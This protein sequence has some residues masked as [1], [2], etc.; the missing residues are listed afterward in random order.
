MKTYTEYLT[1]QTEKASEI[2][3][4][5]DKVKA[6]LQKSEFREGLVLV[7]SLHAN[8]GVFVSIYEPLFLEDLEAWL[9]TLSPLRDDYK[10]RK[11]ESNAG[12]LL[13]TLL[14]NPQVAVGFSEGRLDLGPWQE[15]LYAEFDGQRPKRVLMKLMGE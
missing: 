5:T 1:I 14:V 12:T 2:M 6:A 8:S 3:P 4:I 15:V 7:S 11:F 9:D 10:F 13:R